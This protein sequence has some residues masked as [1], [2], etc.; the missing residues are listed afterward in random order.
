MATTCSTNDPCIRTSDSQFLP[1]R[2][3]LVLKQIQSVDIQKRRRPLSP[4]AAGEAVSSS[5]VP[6]F[7]AGGNSGRML[8][9]V[10]VDVREPLLFLESNRRRRNPMGKPVTSASKRGSKSEGE[11]LVDA[12]K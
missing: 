10:A 8:Q 3:D 5:N 9:V 11:Q 4:I 6:L 1:S 2:R 7:V 12:S